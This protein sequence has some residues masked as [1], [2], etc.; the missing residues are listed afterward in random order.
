MISE[1]VIIATF[2]CGARNADD[3]THAERNLYLPMIYI[4]I[5]ETKLH[6]HECIDKRN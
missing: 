6:A 5:L 2:M 3:L 1:K 4:S